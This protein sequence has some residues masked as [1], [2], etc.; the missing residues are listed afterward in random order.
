MKDGI[1]INNMTVM[2][3]TEV[4]DTSAIYYTTRNLLS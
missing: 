1:I 4:G 2:R 3:N